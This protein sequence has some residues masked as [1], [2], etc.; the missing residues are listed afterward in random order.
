MWRYL[1]KFPS[2]PLSKRN[3][4]AKNGPKNA[5]LATFAYLRTP[6]VVFYG[7]KIGNCPLNLTILTIYNRYDT[8]KPISEAR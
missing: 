5:K 6:K 1:E 4:L 3:V 2:I 8:Q 7:K